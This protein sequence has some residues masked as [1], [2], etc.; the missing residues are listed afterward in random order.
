VTDRRWTR[1]A[2][3]DEGLGPAESEVMAELEQLGLTPLTPPGPFRT[4]AARARLLAETLDRSQ[5]AAALPGL[6]RQIGT[7]MAEARQAVE[8]DSA[9]GL[10]VEEREEEV[11]DFERERKKRR[12]PAAGDA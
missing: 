10:A 11:S 9:G 2:G 3:S 1:E 6:D 7:V 5:N 12:P 8:A 4:A